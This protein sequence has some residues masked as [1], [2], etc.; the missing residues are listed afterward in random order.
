MFL[1]REKE[2]SKLKTFLS[3][4]NSTAAMI[5]GVRQIGKS[6]LI[7]KS[8]EGMKNILYYECLDSTTEENIKQ[9]SRR[10]RTQLQLPEIKADDIIELFDNL[11]AFNRNFTIIL[12][13]YQ[14]LKRNF[15]SGNMDSYMQSIIDSL[16]GSG[17]KIILSG[18]YVSEMKEL[19]LKTNPL[20]NRFQ[21]IIHLKELD[22][23]DAAAF[24]PDL[25]SREKAMF[26]SVFG[27]SP[28]AL[29]LLNPEKS[30]EDNIKEL[31]LHESAPLRFCTVSLP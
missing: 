8:I 12:D 6:A 18:S 19:L 26:Y 31:F 13:E 25:S 3:S 28:N 4:E 14:Y 9:I 24:Y 1:K 27:G 29:S 2:L 22:Y 15:T 11:K 5:Y 20:F 23:Y 17:I 30:L 10:I 16:K 21:L 7:L